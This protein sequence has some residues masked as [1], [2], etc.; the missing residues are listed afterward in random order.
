MRTC[1]VLL[2]LSFS[3][4]GQAM[5]GSQSQDGQSSATAPARPSA[6]DKE[7]AENG[8]KP[9]ASDV[10][11]DAT[12]IT[13]EGLCGGER[14]PAYTESVKTC[15]TLIRRAEFEKLTNSLNPNMQPEA[16]RE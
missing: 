2:L 10:A 8:S 4:V 15:R 11:P 13:V 14:K 9:G 1:W 5:A 6:D 3:L 12:V 7:N 16:K